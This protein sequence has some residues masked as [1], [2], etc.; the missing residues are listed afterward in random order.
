MMRDMI[1]RRI[2]KPVKFGYIMADSWF[3]STE[4]KRFIEKKKFLCELR[5]NRLAAVNERER[6]GGPCIRIEEYRMKNRY[7]YI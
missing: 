2:Q 5:D 7:R 6:K 4:N 1:K 3:A